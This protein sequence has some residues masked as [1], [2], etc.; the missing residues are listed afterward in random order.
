MFK[1]HKKEKENKKKTANDKMT[2][3]RQPFV[4]FLF[5]N[6]LL[7]GIE[8]KNVVTQGLKMI[9][10]QQRVDLHEVI[11]DLNT[12]KNLNEQQ[13]KHLES[14]ENTGK[15][16][17]KKFSRGLNLEK[18]N[19]YKSLEWPSQT[20]EITNLRLNNLET[21]LHQMIGDIQLIGEEDHKQRIEAGNQVT[22]L[23]TEKKGKWA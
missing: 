7:H 23:I 13:W 8:R 15:K 2:I 6:T 3:V 18:E 9:V 1:R 17:P 4:F 14:L 5:S 12:L 22:S 21:L 11:A 16:I 20:Q 19:Q 10:D